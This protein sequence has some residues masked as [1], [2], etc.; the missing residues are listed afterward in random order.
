MSTVITTGEVRLSY[1]NVFEPSADPSGN[2]KYSAMLLIPKTDTKTIAAIETAIK[3]ATVLGKDKKFQGKIPAKLTSPLQDG[4]GVR[5]TDG[6]P[7]GEE[8][9]GHYLINAKANPSYPPKVVDR[10]LQEIL[11]QSE[12]YSGCYARANISFYAYNTN[13]NKGIACG[14]NAIQKTRDGE[15]LGGTRVSVDDAFGDEFFEDLADD[16]IF[17]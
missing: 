17:G 2:L 1:V 9:H 6:E 13:G 10:H 3:E 4:D 15:P 11:D 16:S 7:Y 5:P 12:V 8:C 14:L